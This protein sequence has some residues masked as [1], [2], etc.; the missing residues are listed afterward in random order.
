MS[1]TP[2]ASPADMTDHPSL[3]R[4][5]A[6]LVARREHLRGVGESSADL[7]RRVVLAALRDGTRAE[8]AATLGVNLRTL[9]RWI[10]Y[11]EESGADVSQRREGA[12]V[13]GGTSRET[14]R[15]A[16]LTQGA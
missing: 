7:W 15:R 1:G 12:G 9:H 14:L 10:D 8:A 5:G 13:R 2:R 4:T 6:E 3:S 11:L 16:R